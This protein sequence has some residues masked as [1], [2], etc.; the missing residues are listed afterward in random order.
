MSPCRSLVWDGDPA[1]RG[2]AAVE[3]SVHSE[4]RRR[5]PLVPF[6]DI[7]MDGARRYLVKN[8]IPREGLVVLYGAPK[9]GKTFLVTDLVLHI[10]LGLPYRGRQVQQGV[11]VYIACEG[12]R[13]LAA[14][15]EAF[16]R[17]KLPA[18]A[19]PAFF[20]LTTRL[21]LFEDCDQLLVEMKAQLGGSIPVAIVIDTLNRS[22]RGSESNDEDMGNYVKAAD[23]LREEFAAAVIIVHHCGIDDRRP[24]GHTSLVGAADAQIAV[25]RERD[26]E[27]AARIEYMKDG[28]AGEEIVGRLEVVELGLDED[29]EQITS[30]VLVPAEVEER[31][32]GPKLSRATRRALDLLRDTIRE[33]GVVPLP[34]AQ[35]PAGISCATIEQWREDCRKGLP[36]EGGDSAKRKAF[37]RARHELLDK[38][39]IGYWADWFWLN[40]PA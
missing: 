11:V 12:E 35:I 39:V 34:D 23:R 36:V 31:S 14:R 9:C 19:E 32:E 40:E 33:R 16:R 5:F 25:R 20:L 24:R 22:L 7:K 21:D 10:A 15:I 6:A 8:V 3:R 1:M 13:G 28:A 37:Q 29:G 27:V 18:G 26:G 30:C 17:R 4:A 2:Q 38:H